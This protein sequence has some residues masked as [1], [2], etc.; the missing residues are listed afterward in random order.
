MINSNGEFAVAP[1]TPAQIQ[2]GADTYV[3]YSSGLAAKTKVWLNF[4]SNPDNTPIRATQRFL[5]YHEV[6]YK[7]LVSEKLILDAVMPA[8][9]GGITT[10]DYSAQK[11]KGTYLVGFWADKNLPIIIGPD[12]KAYITDGHHTTAG[13]LAANVAS[14]YIIPG[15]EH[16]VIGTI[17][18][19][20]YDPAAS[21]HP[22][23]DDTW[24]LAR[25]R[26][27]NALLYGIN[28]NQ[29]TRPGD[30]GYA[31]LQPIL[32][33][34]EAM[35]MVPGKAGMADESLRSL[36]W[37]MADGIVKSATNSGGTRLAGF[38]KASTVNPGFDTNFVEFYWCDF[39][40]NR[41]T[42]DDTKTGST[43]ATTRADRNLVQAPLGFY[44]AV[45]N[46]IALAK[47]EVYRDQY[48]RSLGDYN[49][50]VSSPTTRNW[51]IDSTS[52]GRLAVAGD[53]YHMYLLDD[54]GVAGDITPSLLSQT[55]N[56]LHIDTTIGQTIDGVIANFG[57]SVDINKGSSI[58]TQWKDG[59]LN[60]TAYNST[61]TIAPGAGTVT[62]TGA[63]T[64]SGPTNIG[65]GTLALGA[66]GSIDSSTS[67]TVAAGATFDT[68]AQAGYVMPTGQPFAIGID[69]AGS[70]SGGRIH[71]SG[72]DITHA[73]VSFNIANPLDDRVYV[74]GSYTSLT[75]T[76]FA[77]VSAPS[78]Y[79][80]NYTYN[81]NQIALVSSYAGWAATY[82]PGQ[83]ADQNNKHDGV[84]NG[85]KYFMGAT[86]SSP[87]VAPGIVG[88]AITWPKSPQ[89]LGTYGVEVSS[90]LAAWEPATTDYASYITDNGASVV[91][92]LPHVPGNLF[93]RLRVTPAP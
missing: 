79:A 43:L 72:L 88:G 33:G 80:I 63:N 16:V 15:Y 39:L 46:G 51:A 50:G 14:R 69:G 11:T 18:A 56:A 66:S 2:I 70:G 87:T 49:S 19:N 74:I 23:P 68:T 38:S 8:T 81:G 53:N 62:F 40:R 44:A 71:A 77:T 12:G 27:N 28:G 32:S 86:G 26:E 82:A 65:A 93:T 55:N 76:A 84:P 75:G 1:G 60:T 17:V 59:A 83:T 30:S 9:S 52:G 45:A 47:S 10:Y 13:Y 5:G 4:D 90:D 48:G 36:A 21:T 64:Y 54:S 24:W 89:F 85:V 57:K 7:G 91:F 78:G 37:G 22:A 20:Y 92:E 3:Q 67:V 41:I 29:L 58:S 61:L 25:E 6:D 73:S 42:W 35:P 31:G 34:I